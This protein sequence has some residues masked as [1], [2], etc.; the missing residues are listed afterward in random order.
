MRVWVWDFPYL[1]IQNN[2]FINNCHFFHIELTTALT[3]AVKATPAAVN[4]GALSAGPH[5]KVRGEFF[6]PRVKL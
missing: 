3:Q 6:Q 1:S 5:V 4:N 2:Q